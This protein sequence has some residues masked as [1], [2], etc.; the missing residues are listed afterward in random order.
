MPTTYKAKLPAPALA[1]QVLS[2]G[3]DQEKWML[4][5]GVSLQRLLALAVVIML[6]GALTACGDQV[7]TF[8]ASDITGM[9]V[10][11]DFSLTD[12]TGKRRTLGDFK[13]KVVVLFFGYTHCPDVCP[14][15]M[16]EVNAALTELGGKAK[17]VQVLFVTVDPDRDTQELLAQYVPAFNPGFLGL[18]G[19]QEELEAAARTF[20]VFYQKVPTG[21]SGVYTMDHTAGS[22]VFD[23]QGRIRLLVSYGAGASV[24]AHDLGQLLR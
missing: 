12:H 4:V 11:G 18:R 16:S 3:S 5:I 9:N 10:G 7:V 2:T 17:D 24:F 21:R 13:G 19:N 20:K 8:K 1:F 22:F 23:K 15:T 6:A 14:T